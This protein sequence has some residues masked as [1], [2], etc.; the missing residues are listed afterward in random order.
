MMEL[1]PGETI[2][3]QGRPST[4][5]GS[6]RWF[7]LF[8]L[9]FALFAAFFFIVSLASTSQGR[10][11]DP[12]EFVTVGLFPL[13]VF[14]LF[15]LLPRAIS[16][17]RDTRGIRYV[18][19]DRRAIIAT[20]GRRVELDLRTIPHLELD[21]SWLSGPTIYFGQRNIYDGMWGSSSA[22]ALRGLANADEVYAMLT[23]IRSRG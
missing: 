14:G 21:R 12:S 8:Y 1:L 19:T 6:L 16:V 18:V 13:V 17:W 10:A 20:R 15:F 23:S 22:P 7:D 9:G 3:W 2:V 5:R 4:A 11:R